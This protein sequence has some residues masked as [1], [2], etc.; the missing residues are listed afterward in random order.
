VPG[1]SLEE[2]LPVSTFRE[3]E[4]TSLGERE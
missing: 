1:R 3:D 4:L 2:E